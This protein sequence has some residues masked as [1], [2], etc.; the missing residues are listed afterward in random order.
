MHD[1]PPTAEDLR[2]ER[3]RRQVTI[4]RIAAK[5]SL[6]PGRLGA[7]LNGKLPLSAEMAQRIQA[8][9]RSEETRAQ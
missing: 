5:V 7:V 1:T 2:S 8:A 4:Y 6:N 9:I 3:A